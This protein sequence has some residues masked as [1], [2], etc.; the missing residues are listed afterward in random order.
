MS[1]SFGQI[2][3]PQGLNSWV[4]TSAF[5]PVLTQ[6]FPVTLGSQS[7]NI[8]AVSIQSPLQAQRELMPLKPESW[9]C[10]K[11]ERGLHTSPSAEEASPAQQLLVER[12]HLMAPN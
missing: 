2:T 12:W 4:W 7:Q 3:E 10:L 8:A 11:A 5:H 1:T 9:S 6:T